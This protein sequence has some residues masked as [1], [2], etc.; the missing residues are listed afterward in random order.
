MTDLSRVKLT[1]KFVTADSLITRQ[2]FRLLMGWISLETQ[3]LLSTPM[4]FKPFAFIMGHLFFQLGTPLLQFSAAKKH[5]VVLL[6]KVQFAI[7]VLMSPI[8]FLDT[9]G[10]VNVM[11]LNQ[12]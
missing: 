12:P 6:V 1:W 2:A 7:L 9:F 8:F 3:V 11:Q 4:K 10:L 5:K